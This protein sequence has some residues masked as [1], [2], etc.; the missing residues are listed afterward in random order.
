MLKRLRQ[1]LKKP[2]IIAAKPISKQHA[3]R[4]CPLGGEVGHVGGYQF[5]GNVCRIL[6]GQDVHAFGHGIMR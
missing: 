6:P 2:R 1:S 3:E 5:P 4:F